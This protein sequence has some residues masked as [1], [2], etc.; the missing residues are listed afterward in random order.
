MDCQKC[1]QRQANVHITQFV[2]GEKQEVHLCEQCA[3]AGKIYYPYSQFPIHNLT[4]L[5]GFLMQSGG[6]DKHLPEDKCPNCA[7]DYQKI[8]ESG[9]IGCSACYDHF[10]TQLEPVLRKIHG[11]SR[12]SGKIPKRMGTAF[13]LKKEVEELKKDL[14][15][16]IEYEKYEE[17]ATI[18]D[19]IKALEEKIVRGE[20]DD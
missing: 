4:N 9:Y 18:R 17:A 16:A 11:T 5:L 10:S 13:L 14:K 15:K 19:S 12:H 8:T 3:Q 1:H 6:V 2:N 20:N 7:C